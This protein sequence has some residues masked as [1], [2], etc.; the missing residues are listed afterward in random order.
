MQQPTHT[1]P[2][3][4]SPVV[5]ASSCAMHRSSVVLP[6]PLFPRTTST[7]GRL[8]ASAS[9]GTAA[10]RS[11]ENDSPAKSD[12]PSGSVLL[13]PRTENDVAGGGAASHAGSAFFR[14]VNQDVWPC[15]AAAAIAGIK[16]ARPTTAARA[17]R[18]QGR[19]ATAPRRAEHDNRRNNRARGHSAAEG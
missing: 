12:R 7:S 15:V 10:A 18:D 11:S 5:N 17:K 13:R 2:R 4:I 1:P 8:A 19:A 14:H 6:A 3:S 16:S 9:S